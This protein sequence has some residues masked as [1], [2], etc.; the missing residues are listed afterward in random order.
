[1]STHDKK[2]THRQSDDG[3]QRKEHALET[4]EILIEGFLDGD[5]PPGGTASEVILIEEDFDDHKP[6]SGVTGWVISAGV[7]GLLFLLF[8][9]LVWI[10]KAEEVELPPMHVINIDPPPK[11][12]EKKNLERTLD[13][14]VE[15][16]VATEA[17]V[18]AP[19]TPMEMPLE[20]KTTS[21][22][23]N[24]AN[25][26]KG[27]EEAVASNET[28]STGAFMTIGP[29]GGTA[30]MFGSRNGGGKRRALAKGGGSRASENAVDAA[31]RWFT[32][33]QSPDGSW[34]VQ[35]YMNNCTEAGPKC[36]PGHYERGETSRAGITGMVVL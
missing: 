11:V 8:G 23:N 31:L 32:R 9:A 24:E 5:E 27:R 10:A 14:K 1:M 26:A 18:A 16:N 2:V 28:G 35:N 22:D 4:D 3:F 33:H 20:E 7:H 15:I 29:G 30:G 19:I 36:E 25:I 34:D 6:R 17:E 12:E 21:E 13:N